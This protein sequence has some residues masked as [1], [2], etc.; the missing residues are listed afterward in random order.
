M[1]GKISSFWAG[2]SGSCVLYLRREDYKNSILANGISLERNEVTQQSRTTLTS[3]YIR[4]AGTFR[5]IHTSSGSFA[6][7]IERVTEATLWSDP[8]HPRIERY[9]LMPQR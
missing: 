9:E 4:I 3:K 7:R 6:A 8:D 2:V 1:I 5:A